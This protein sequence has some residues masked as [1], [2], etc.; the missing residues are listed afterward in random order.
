MLQ[1]ASSNRIFDT[2]Y[3]EFTFATHFSRKTKLLNKTKT[4]LSNEISEKKINLNYFQLRHGAAL[5]RNKGHE[6]HE[7]H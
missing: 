3:F 4:K 6:T 7:H 1:N 2:K 5:R